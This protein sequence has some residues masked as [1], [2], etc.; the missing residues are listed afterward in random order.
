MS[1]R[2]KRWFSVGGSCR[3]RPLIN[4]D[5]SGFDEIQSDAS[6]NESLLQWSRLVSILEKYLL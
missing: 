3:F 1:N 5:D 2:L 4:S 6:A